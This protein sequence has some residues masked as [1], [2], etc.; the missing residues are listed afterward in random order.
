MCKTLQIM[1]G[2]P[3]QLV[4]DF[5][6]QQ[7]SRLIKRSLIS[8]Y[9]LNKFKEFCSHFIQI[10]G[11]ISVA[12]RLLNPKHSPNKNSGF[13]L[14]ETNIF[15]PENGW[16]EYSFSFGAQPIFRGKLAVSF[17]ECTPSPVD[18]LFLEPCTTNKQ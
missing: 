16:L 15:A 5:F 4:Q 18:S 2:S 10:L 14:P 12:M 9:P 7:Y 13:T 3:Y 17:R 1:V 8:K 11:N 6:H